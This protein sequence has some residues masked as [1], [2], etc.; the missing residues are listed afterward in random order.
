MQEDAVRQRSALQLI[1]ASLSVLG[2]ELALIRWIPGQV[3]VLAYFPNIVLISAFL[4]LGIGCLL[5]T[6]A[7][8]K[9]SFPTLLLLLLGTSLW[10][11]RFAFTRESTSQHLWLLYFDQPDRQVVNGIRLPIVT[12]FVLCAATFVPLGHFVA[13]RLQEFREAGRSLRGYAADLGGSLLGVIAFTLLFFSR[14]FPVVWFA[15]VLLTTAFL[16]SWRDKRSLV[17]HLLCSAAILFFVQKF[18]RA[19]RTAPTTR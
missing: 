13:L 16:W 14:T 18:E 11:S 1:L 17:I 9:W 3:R 5:V 12:I 8:P 4:G 15:A 19:Q 6:R 7:V 2:L 10:L